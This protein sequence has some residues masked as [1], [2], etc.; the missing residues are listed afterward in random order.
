MSEKDYYNILG[1]DKTASKNEIKKKYRKLAMKYHPDHTKGDKAA[2]KKF[3]DVS[4]AYAVLSDD[5]KRKQYDTF[6]SADFQQQFSQEDI[7][8][9]F[10]FS[11]IFSEFGFGNGGFSQGPNGGMRFSFGG[12]SPFG[13]R[14]KQRQAPVKGTDLEYELPLTLNDV[15]NGTS[16]TVSLRHAGS[17][18]RISVKIP[19]GMVTGKRLRLSGK[20]EPSPYGGPPGDLFIKARVMDDAAFRVDGHDLHVE[21]KIKLSEAVLGSTVRISTIDKKTIDLTIP[22]GTNHKTNMRMSAHGLP[23]MNDKGRGDLYV[24]ILV[25][26]PKTLNKSQKE[27]FAKLSETGL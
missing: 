2:E 4:E 12:G 13:G 22:P 18:E 11:N 25:D 17:D 21:K 16:K 24:H 20:G 9:G 27:L 3:K 23:R 15:M 26:M 8:K 7:F 6:G 19:K 10:D 5:K 1:V 14:R